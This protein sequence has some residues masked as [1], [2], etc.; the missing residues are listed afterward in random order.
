MLV[1]PVLPSIVIGFM[2][3]NA[4][5][6]C[7]P[8]ARKALER[9]SQAAPR[10]A[11]RFSQRSLA[12]FAWFLSPVLLLSVRGANN[13]WS[14]TNEGVYYRPMFSPAPKRHAWPEVQSV[15]TG[16][17]MYRKIEYQSVMT[18]QDGTH[19]E[20]AQKTPSSFGLLTHRSSKL[21]RASP[22]GS[23]RTVFLGQVWV[24]GRGVVWS[25]GPDDLRSSE[26]SLRG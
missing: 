1:A 19:I 12:R 23:A 5:V 11:F 15:E 7:I 26:V 24:R 3:G 20:L 13:F 14:L 21:S 17:T 16:C 6:W 2:M 10:A 8:W 4:L 9:E 22:T 18:L 25:F